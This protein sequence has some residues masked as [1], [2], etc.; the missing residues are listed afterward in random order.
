MV[1]HKKQEQYQP[2]TNCTN[3]PVLGSFRNWNIIQ[4]PQK[5]TPYDVFDE[6]QHVVLDGISDNMASLVKF[7]KYGAMNKTGTAT[8]GFYII[9][10]TPEAYILQDNT[11]N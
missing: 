9:M 2:F 5:S 11:N 1:Y 3:W 10:F 8:N 6:I 4:L 7:S